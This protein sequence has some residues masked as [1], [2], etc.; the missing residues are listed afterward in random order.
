M[1]IVSRRE[2]RYSEVLG[3]YAPTGLSRKQ[4]SKLNKLVLKTALFPGTFGK[5]F[6]GAASNDPLFWVMHQMFDKMYHGLRL[7]PKYNKKPFI[8]NN[9]NQV[10][11]GMGWTDETPF[12]FADFEPWLGP[13]HKI[14][15][16]GS[17]DSLS[18]EDL[19]TLLKPDGDILPYMYDQLSSWGKCSFDPTK[20]TPPDD[21]AE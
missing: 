12:K 9:E 21:E 10:S 3:G 5:H 18:N 11:E 16:P 20:L 7:S 14:S 8:W 17:R 13:H 15:S 19:W 4:V 1:F 6:G 2:N